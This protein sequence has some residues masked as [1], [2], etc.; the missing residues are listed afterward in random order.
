MLEVDVFEQPRFC[1]EFSHLLNRLLTAYASLYKFPLQ[2]V[3]VLDVLEVS[4]K[5]HIYERAVN[6][7][8]HQFP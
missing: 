3:D 2:L 8:F 5:C 4:M 1:D 7:F 6:Q